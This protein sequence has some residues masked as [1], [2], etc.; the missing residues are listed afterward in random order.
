MDQIR[1]TPC[2]HHGPIC[3][4]CNDC[5]KYKGTTT[6]QIREKICDF[7]GNTLH[8]FYVDG[9]ALYASYWGDMCLTCF[10]SKGLGLGPGRGQLYQYDF[11]T[12]EW[13]K[14]AG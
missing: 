7:C 2:S 11:S 5:N 9:R 10:E 1:D 13:V 3:S 4:G 6:Q 14:I 8:R 12:K